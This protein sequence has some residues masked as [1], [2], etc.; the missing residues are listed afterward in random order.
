MA[1]YTKKRDYRLKGKMGKIVLDDHIRE[2]VS[3]SGIREGYVMVFVAGCVGALAVTE[4]E[5]NIM[6]HDIDHLFSSSLGLPYGEHF[7]DGTSYHHHQ[8]WHDDNGSSHLRALLLNHSLSIPVLDG[9]V[10]LGP[11]QNVVLIEFDTKDRQRSLY[12]Q[13]Q[14]E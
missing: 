5:P 7:A 14:G 2:V 10:L 13:V 12:Y 1:V 4:A 6:E 9:E 8:T 3:D 11:W